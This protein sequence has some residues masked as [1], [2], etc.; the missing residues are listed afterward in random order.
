MSTV[1]VV[2]PAFRP[3]VERTLSY[4]RELE[5]V[6]SPDV[7]RLELD[8]PDP[9]V[10]AAFEGSPATV[11]AVDRRRGKG[12][13]IAE[14]FDT[15]ETDVL[16][17]FD[18]D[19]ATPAA[20][21]EAVVAPVRRGEVPLAVGSRRHP[22]SRVAGH[23]GVTRRV[24]GDAFA[25]SARRLLPAT[26]YDYQCGAKAIS[27]GTWRNVRKHLSETGFGWDIELI[28]TAAALGYKIRE[29]PIE[30]EDQPGS[31][32][33]PAGDGLRMARTLLS[34]SLC[35][36]NVRRQTDRDGEGMET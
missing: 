10:V 35:A 24:L 4:L 22:D 18:A 15:L 33:S 12:A 31:T 34:A 14:G 16:A 8:D 28:A 36:R 13:A 20:S 30:W 3:E 17:F 1:G 26:L 9:D 11:N 6:L 29:V 7:I 5:S 19:G 23:Q 25:W 32:V 2:I 27:A 21:A